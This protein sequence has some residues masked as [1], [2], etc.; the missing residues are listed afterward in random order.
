MEKGQVGIDNI[1]ACQQDDAI[2]FRADKVFI[3]YNGQNKCPLE[4][5]SEVSQ[6]SIFQDPRV[7]IFD[8]IEYQI[9]NL[10]QVGMSLQRELS[11]PNGEVTIKYYYIP[12]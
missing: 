2:E 10:D 11:G 9:I 3:R 4:A 7:L 12:K 8:S 5:D 6:W 1:P